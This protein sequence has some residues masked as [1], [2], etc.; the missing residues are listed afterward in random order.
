MVNLVPTT[1]GVSIAD[2]DVYKKSPAGATATVA[3]AVSRLGGSSAFISKV[4]FSIILAM[5]VLI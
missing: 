1:V 3:V 4:K 5:F 2:A